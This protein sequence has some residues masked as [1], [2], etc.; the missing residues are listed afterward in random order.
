MTLCNG[1][2]S[3]ANPSTAKLALGYQV[4]QPRVFTYLAASNV[5][6][7]KDR[8][9]SAHRLVRTV[10]TSIGRGANV[11]PALAVDLAA[12]VVVVVAVV[13]AAGRGEEEEVVRARRL[14]RDE[15]LLEE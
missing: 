12:A 8:L 3:R 5:P 2:T 1:I 7:I 4:K 13:R 6:A 9:N 15:V 14:D 10:D 11:A